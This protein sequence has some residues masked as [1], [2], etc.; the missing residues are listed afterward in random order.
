[1]HAD[2]ESIQY[3]QPAKALNNGNDVRSEGVT[4][5]PHFAILVSSVLSTID[6]HLSAAADRAAARSNVSGCE[7]SLEKE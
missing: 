3:P 4:A 7:S 1:M 6:R 5:K 2:V